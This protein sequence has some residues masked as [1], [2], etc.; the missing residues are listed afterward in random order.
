MRHDQH[1]TRLCFKL[2][3]TCRSVQRMAHALTWDLLLRL[4]QHRAAR[5]HAHKNNNATNTHTHT[6]TWTG[7][8]LSAIATRSASI[9]RH[10]HID[11]VSLDH[12]YTLFASLQGHTSSKYTPRLVQPKSTISPLPLPLISYVSTH[13]CARSTCLSWQDNT[14]NRTRK[15]ST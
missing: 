14:P 6:H 12:F 1:S 13:L 2:E 5:A 8:H 15:M 11:I 7:L 10:H 4:T 3:V 9:S